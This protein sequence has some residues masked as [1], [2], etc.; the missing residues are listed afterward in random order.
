MPIPDS[1][2]ISEDVAHLG[3]YASRK[4]FSISNF[5]IVKQVSSLCSIIC[6]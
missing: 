3:T 1:Q 2:R 5:Y 4:V 6:Y